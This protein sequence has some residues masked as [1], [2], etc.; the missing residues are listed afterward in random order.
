MNEPSWMQ[1]TFITS[2]N[3]RYNVTNYTT[4]KCE[5]HAFEESF[6]CFVCVFFFNR[7]FFS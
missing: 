2:Y 7:E 5:S 3:K 4:F 1:L 6:L